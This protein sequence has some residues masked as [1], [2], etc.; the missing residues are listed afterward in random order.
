MDRIYDVIVIGAGV[1]GACTARELARFD[2]DTLVLEGGNDLS[3]GASRAN[4]GIVHAGYDPKPGSLKARFNVEGARLMPQWANELRFGYRNNGSMVVA[5]SDDQRTTLETL[6]NRGIE[7]G[8]EGLKLISGDEARELEPNLSPDIVAVL[9]VPTAGICDPYGLSLA[10]MEN[11]LANGAALEFNKRVENIL[12]NDDHTQYTITCADGS[13]YA[14]RTVVNAAGVFSDELNNMVSDNKLAITP[15]RG[16]YCLYHPDLGTKFNNTIFQVPGPAGKGVLVSPTV[17]GNLFVGPNSEPQESKT[18]VSTTREGLDTIIAQA[19][20]SWPDCNGR[21]IITNFAGLRARGNTGDFVI[22]EPDDAPGFFNA[23]CIESPGLT[24]APAIGAFLAQAIA[25]KLEAQPNVGFNPLREAHMPFV[26]MTEAERM[27]AAQN[28]SQWSHV[29]CRCCQVTEA[30]IVAAL[31]SP[32]PV[33][34]LDSLKWRTGVTMGPC[35]GGFC[36]PE[37]LRIIARELG[38]A[39]EY[40]EKRLVGSP[41]IDHARPDFVE[42]SSAEKPAGPGEEAAPDPAS[43]AYYPVVVVGAGAA[44]LAAVRA[45]RDAGATRVLVVDRESHPGGILRQCIHNGF[46]LHRFRETLTGPEYASKEAD[47]LDLFGV[48]TAWANTVLGIERQDNGTF[49]LILCGKHGVSRVHAGAIVLATGSRERGLGSLNLAGSRPAGIFTAGCAQNLIN[50]QGC[51]PGKRAVVLGSGDIGLIMARR[52]S[53]SGMEVEGVYEIAPE[54]SGLKRNIVQCLDDFDIPLHL[55]STAV[56]I[57]GEGRLSAVWVADY[58]ASWKPIPGTE[59]RI[60]CDTLVLSIGLI[61][62]NELAK[63]A[64]VEID[65]VTGGP[66]VDDSLM[67]SVPGIFSCGNSLHVHD[68]AD[69]ASVEGDRAGAQ[70]ALWAKVIARRNLAQDDAMQSAFEAATDLDISPVGSVAAALM[71]QTPDRVPVV[72]GDGVRYVVPQTVTCGAGQPTTLSFRVRASKR[73]VRVAV[74]GVV[75]GERRVIRSQRKKIVL[76]SE[77]I[78]VAADLT[79]QGGRYESIIVEVQEA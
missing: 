37:L 42:L 28:D 18:D 64:G 21:N 1:V 77:M 41:L 19:R 46:G 32:V 47:C 34:S 59:R 35:H 79:P 74:V 16:E 57:E 72:A 22:G 30:E 71:G 54:P 13:I 27:Q 24:S 9:H 38:V 10:A 58:D 39:P 67:T 11:A 73:N 45:A 40:V 29:V 3:C 65:P 33:L 2:L 26:Q 8:V 61:P 68:L 17:H 52:M 50:L 60:P 62:E 66:L 15:T 76:P 51:I 12:P 44:G 14:T 75:N 56:R 55:S 49:D 5:F 36:T 63:T 78:H 43:D 23:A 7:N 4:S 70:A 25:D 48:K 53:L 31:H 6:L 69:N 20:L